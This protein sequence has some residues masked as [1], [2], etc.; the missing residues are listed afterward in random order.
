MNLQPLF[1]LALTLAL[2][3]GCAQQASPPGHALTKV[4]F[5][6]SWLPQGSMAGVIV[7]IDKGFYAA[8]QLDVEAVRG[9]GGIRTTNEVDQGM[10]DFA[11]GDPLSVILNRAHGGS[12]RLVG[13]INQRWPAGL[14]FLKEYKH[15]AAPADLK[16]LT[17]GGGQNSAV[18]TL[19]P[20]WLKRNNVDPAG[21]KILQLNP[22][23]IVASL[24]E[25]K[26][27]AAE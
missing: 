20:L 19:L 17:V 3:G 1:G 24:I 4:T 16:G 2:T 11:Y 14:C 25:G 21:V 8:H 13:I 5:N 23:V 6:M 22:S 18:Q 10:F 27:D 9:F 15:I 26:I 12:A 7:A